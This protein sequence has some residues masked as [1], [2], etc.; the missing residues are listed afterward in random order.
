MVQ[1]PGLCRTVVSQCSHGLVDPVSRK[2]YHKATALDTNNVEFAKHLKELSPVCKLAKVLKFLSPLE[3][4]LQI[5]VRGDISQANYNSMGTILILITTA[6]GL[7]PAPHTIITGV[8]HRKTGE[9]FIFTV[10]A[11]KKSRLLL[12][13]RR[14]HPVGEGRA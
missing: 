6:C 7:D 10:H 4:M 5:Q 3:I 13:V 12:L 9:Q 1:R 14:P 8:S 11:C 2:A